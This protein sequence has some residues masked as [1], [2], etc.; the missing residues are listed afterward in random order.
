M[1]KN[2]YQGFLRT[3]PSFELK[4]IYIYVVDVRNCT[5]LKKIRK[6]QA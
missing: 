5:G 3:D 6:E 2:I 4:V 1:L